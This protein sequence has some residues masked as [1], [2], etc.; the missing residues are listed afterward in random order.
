MPVYRAL[1]ITSK[2]SGEVRLAMFD[3]RAITQ[4]KIDS[5]STHPSHLA[6]DS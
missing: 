1:L 3:S 2:R 5:R 6:G 4:D